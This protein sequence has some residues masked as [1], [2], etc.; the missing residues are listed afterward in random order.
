MSTT[1]T[2]RAS[3]WGALFDCAHKW[4]GVHILKM[5]S[6]SGLRAQLGTAIHAGTAAYDQAGLDGD[7]ITI[8]DAAGYVVDALH[9]PDREVDYSRD[10]LTVGQAEQIGIDLL[11]LYCREIAPQY[12]YRAVEL[13]TEPLEIDCGGGLV[14]R[15]TGTLDRSRIVSTDGRLCIADI[16]TG[17]AAV[18]KGNAKTKGHAAQVGTY[19]LLFEHTTG[20]AI[21]A[22]AEIIG[23]KTKGTPEVAVGQIHNARQMLL[24]TEESPGLIGYGAEMLRSGLFPPNPQSMMCSERYCPRWNKCIY[25]W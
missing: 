18:S 14:I 23:L 22:P 25:H 5:P 9:N 3:S 17:G 4:E 6:I 16:K 11:S 15:L 7:P 20:E 24:G 21:T 1:V 8:F 10:D 13:P 12:Q 19:E 2:I